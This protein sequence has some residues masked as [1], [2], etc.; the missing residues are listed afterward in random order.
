MVTT[1]T[2]CRHARA[3]MRQASET[4]KKQLDGYEQSLV[5]KS[6]YMMSHLSTWAQGHL[7]IGR[8]SEQGL[9][10]THHVIDVIRKQIGNIR[11]E[12]QLLHSSRIYNAGNLNHDEK[13]EEKKKRFC[14]VCHLGIAKKGTDYC[15]CLGKRENEGED[16]RKKKK[17]PKSV[18][19]EQKQPEAGDNEND[20]EE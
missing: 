19:A 18:T 11:R 15:R 17:I 12:L 16:K 6:H 5:M 10:S 4:L 2:L 3:D 13:A 1:I 8:F 9:E 7:N 14:P 20:N